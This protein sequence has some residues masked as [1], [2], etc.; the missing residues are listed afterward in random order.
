MHR[1]RM[2][3]LLT[4]LAF[5]VPFS[6][7]EDLETLLNDKEAFETLNSMYTNNLVSFFNGSTHTQK[8][9]V[10]LIADVNDKPT[11]QKILDVLEIQFDEAEAELENL[12]AGTVYGCHGFTS[13]RMTKDDYVSAVCL[14]KKQ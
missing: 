9:C 1:L 8:Q 5:L 2:F 10:S 7:A 6:S 4:V 11:W 14:Y 3:V 13:T 12:P